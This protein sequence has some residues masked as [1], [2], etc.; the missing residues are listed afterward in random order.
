M[1]TAVSNKIMSIDEL[2]AKYKPIIHP[3]VK[4]HQGEEYTWRN[5]LFC[6][7]TEDKK[8]IQKLLDEDKEAHIWTIMNSDCGSVEWA[9]SG[10]HY[11]N[12]N[13]FLI[14]EVPYETTGIIAGDEYYKL[15][16]KIVVNVEGMDEN[17]FE[18]LVQD[19]LFESAANEDDFQNLGITFDGDINRVN[20]SFI[21]I[22]FYIYYDENPSVSTMSAAG[23]LIKKTMA[24]IKQNNAEIKSFALDLECKAKP[25][26]S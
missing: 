7:G 26:F 16:G 14:M 17:V 20:E 6:T 12:R 21:N 25:F 9:E 19:E 18:E 13:G 15:E 3:D 11:V 22:N 2:F 10:L 24:E 4:T 5:S 1:N 8:H 23:E